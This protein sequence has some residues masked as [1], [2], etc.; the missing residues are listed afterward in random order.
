MNRSLRQEQDQE[1]IKSLA[2]DKLKMEQK[3]QEEDAK[4]EAEQIQKQR[5]NE[6]H[7]KKEVSCFFRKEK[8]MS[9]VEKY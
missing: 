3:K 5:E 2:T 8:K 9:I 7:R 4:R 6:K 1:Y